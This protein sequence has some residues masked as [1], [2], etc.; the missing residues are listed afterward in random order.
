MTD[1]I[2][3][4]RGMYSWAFSVLIASILVAILPRASV[5]S[6]IAPILAAS[7]SILSGSLLLLRH[8]NFED[9]TASFAVRTPFSP[10]S[11]QPDSP[12]L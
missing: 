11:L 3:E 8:R 10:R 12:Y 6:A 4:W 1:C 2:S 5:T 9:A 7:S